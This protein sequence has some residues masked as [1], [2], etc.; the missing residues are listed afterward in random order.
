MGWRTT[1]FPLQAASTITNASWQRWADLPRYRSSCGCTFCRVRHI[2]RRA[3]PTRSAAATT[4]CR[5]RNSP[6]MPTRH[7]RANRTSSS[8]RWSIGGEGSGSGG[9]HAHVAR[10][11]RQLS[12]L[13]LSANDDMERQRTGDA[14]QQLQLQV[15]HPREQPTTLSLPV[16]PSNKVVVKLGGV[17]GRQVSA[18][19]FLNEKPVE[20]LG[21]HRRRARRRPRSSPP[22]ILPPCGTRFGYSSDENDDGR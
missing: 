18:A 4:P 12:S 20:F 1:P 14:G 21:S 7:R 13:R 3:G 17:F 5:C 10:Q 9:D 2:V 11:Q 19:V 15:T 22:S 8:P 6:A 16:A